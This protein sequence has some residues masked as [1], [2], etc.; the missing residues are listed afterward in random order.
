MRVVENRMR[1]TAGPGAHRAEERNASSRRPPGP[2]Q[3]LPDAPAVI[4]PVKREGE[5][6]KAPGVSV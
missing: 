4:W 6:A 2:F 1:L 5:H 3:R